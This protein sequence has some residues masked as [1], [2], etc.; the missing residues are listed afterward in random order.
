VVARG[1]G[2]E[3]TGVT[4]ILAHILAAHVIFEMSS[5]SKQFMQVVKDVIVVIV[6]INEHREEFINDR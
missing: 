6:K 1:V 4:V 2:D 3:R 5:I